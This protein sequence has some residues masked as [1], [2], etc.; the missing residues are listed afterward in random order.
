M[1]AIHAP[2][3]AD[4]A[5]WVALGPGAESFAR[6]QAGWPVYV[7]RLPDVIDGTD[8]AVFLCG[9]PNGKGRD[10]CRRQARTWLK[11]GAN[12]VLVHWLDGDTEVFG[13]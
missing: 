1:S 3:T 8:I 13:G 9:I 7:E 6:L 4:A 2:M 10:W 5:P 11:G 12:S